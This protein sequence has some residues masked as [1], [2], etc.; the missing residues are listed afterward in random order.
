MF[1]ETIYRWFAS[2]FGD[3]MADYLSGYVCPSEESEGGYLGNNQYILYGFIALGIALA[4]MLVYYY[5]INHPRFN[6]WW[7]WSLMLLLVGVSNFG[8]AVGMLWNEWYTVGTAECLIA[9]EN[10]G[11]D[12][13]TLIGFGI[14][15][16]IVSILF[17]IIFSLAFKWWSTNCKRSPF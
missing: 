2:F 10:G 5:V 13:N 15:N 6:K 16:F 14:A 7:S 11:I 3:D 17:F 9:G 4:V 8:V 12:G 1:F